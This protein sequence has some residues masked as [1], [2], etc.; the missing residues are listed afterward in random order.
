MPEVNYNKM[1]KF[2]SEDYIFIPKYNVANYS[3]KI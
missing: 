3:V 1:L 2:V